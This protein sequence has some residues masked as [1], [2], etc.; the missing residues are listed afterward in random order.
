M[1]KTIS[2]FKLT[3]QRPLLALISTDRRNTLFLEERW[4]V[5]DEITTRSGHWL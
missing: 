5:E 3:I 1:N 2:A 4:S